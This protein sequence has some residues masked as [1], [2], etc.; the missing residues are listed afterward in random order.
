MQTHLLYKQASLLGPDGF[1]LWTGGGIAFLLGRWG[2]QADLVLVKMRSGF[3]I[4]SS[5]PLLAGFGSLPYTVVTQQPCLTPHWCQPVPDAVYVLA[6][7][8]GPSVGETP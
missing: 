5:L 4:M 6:L 3:L 1:S 7:Y 8:A 2:D